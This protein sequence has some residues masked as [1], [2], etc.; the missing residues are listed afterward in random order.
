[1]LLIALASVDAGTLVQ[2]THAI[3]HQTDLPIQVVEGEELEQLI[4]IGRNGCGKGVPRPCWLL[5]LAVTP[6]RAAELLLASELEGMM[7]ELA[8]ESG[9][10]MAWCDGEIT[11]STHPCRTAGDVAVLRQRCR[12]LGGYLTVLRQPEAGELPAWED[13][14]SR[15]LIERVKDQFDPSGLLAPGRLPGV[16]QPQ[17]AAGAEPGVP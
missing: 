13:A 12:Q 9:L 15:F 7:L 2:Q 11:D 5:R 6:Q 10:G 14:S 4:A 17:G 3:R 8:A 16:A 1:M